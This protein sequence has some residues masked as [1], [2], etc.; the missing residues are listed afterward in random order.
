MK[1][2]VT[3][4]A[5]V[6]HLVVCATTAVGQNIDFYKSH[7]RQKTELVEK[8][9]RE[10]AQLS[11]KIK[12]L[13]AENAELRDQLQALDNRTDPAAAPWPKE[14]GAPP[15]TVVD[16]AGMIRK[17]YDFKPDMT[18]LQRSQQLMRLQSAVVGKQAAFKASIVSVKPTM[19]AGKAHI[20]LQRVSKATIKGSSSG[21]RGGGGEVPRSKVEIYTFMNVEQAAK[22]HT[23][24]LVTAR[25]RIRTLR[26]HRASAKLELHFSI[27][28]DFPGIQVIQ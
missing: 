26:V 6:C 2:A 10:N 19:L 18:E 9:R 15:L 17:A 8:L 7:L 16:V 22:L 28:L 27:H 20:T 12:H 3:T 4:A 13:Q 25:G 5:L 23:G 11:A 1:A 21:W 24:M 14:Q